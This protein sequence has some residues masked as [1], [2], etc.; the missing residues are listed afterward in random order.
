MEQKSFLDKILSLDK[1]IIYTLLLILLS[2]PLL[3]PW[4]LPVPPSAMTIGVYTQLETLKP[5]DRVLCLFGLQPADLPEI[6]PQQQLLLQ[7]IIKKGAKAV[8]IDFMYV[9]G[10]TL[11]DLYIIPKLS[12]VKYGENLV[13]IGWVPGL[14]VAQAKFYEDVWGVTQ[15]DFYGKKFADL[16]LMNECHKISDFSMICS[17]GIVDEALGT[18]IAPSKLPTVRGTWA[19]GVT[20]ETPYWKSGQYKGIL[21]GSR[22]AAEYGNMLGI[23]TRSNAM[24]DSISLSHL[25]I[26][27]LVI[28]GNI[29]F[30]MKYEK[31]RKVK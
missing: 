29:G 21:G 26:A 11:Q 18:I 17:V 19:V 5:G 1:R 9:F 16:P 8:I 6:G 10:G 12:G 30:F 28:L 3:R 15:V 24:M 14:A 2:I 7:H 31:G 20:T 27:A 13:N 23:L 25:F 22:G 4:G